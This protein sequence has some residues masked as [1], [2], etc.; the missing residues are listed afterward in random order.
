LVCGANHVLPFRAQAAADGL[1]VEI[2]AEDWQPAA[3]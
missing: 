1:T 3:Y 2:A